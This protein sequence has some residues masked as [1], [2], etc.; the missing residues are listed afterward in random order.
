MPRAPASTSALVSGGISL[1]SEY[2]GVPRRPSRANPVLSPGDQDPGALEGGRIGLD[3]GDGRLDGGLLLLDVLRRRVAPGDRER[4]G[5]QDDDRSALD[6]FRPRSEA[7]SPEKERFLGRL[8]HLAEPRAAVETDRHFAGLVELGF[9]PP[10]LELPNRPV[11]RVVV[12]VRARLPAAEAV[13]GVVVP[14]HDPVV[15]RAEFDDLF[16]DGVFRRLGGR[17]LEADR[18]RDHQDDRQGE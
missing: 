8:D 16:D 13:A 15:G 6:A 10:L 5:L 18:R 11:G 17:F 12:G 7:G 2:S 14:G 3:L 4:V 9:E 1:A